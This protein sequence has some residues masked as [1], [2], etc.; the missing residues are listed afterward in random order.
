MSDK[1]TAPQ[2]HIQIQIEIDPA[3]AMGAFVNMAMVNHTETE[4]TLDLVYVQP[5]AP[6]ATVRARAITTPK[7]MKRLL[8]A[9]QDNLQKYEARFGTI[10]LGDAP[11]FPGGVMN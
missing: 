11:H 4:F 5:Q 6:R 10:D 9:I 2:Q 3:T 7:H 8:L 1:P